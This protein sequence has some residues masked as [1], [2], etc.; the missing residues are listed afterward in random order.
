MQATFHIVLV[1]S[2]QPALNPRLVKEADALTTSGY[3]VT[4]IYQ[5]WNAWGTEIDQ[6]ILPVKK[7]NAIRIGGTPE[8]HKALYWITRVRHKAVKIL[9]KLVGFKYW[10]A[11]RSLSRCTFLLL[12]D[13][14]RQRA[15]LY[16]AH[17]LAALPVAVIAAKK[18]KA[19][20][21]FDAE[22]FH[23]NEITNNPYHMDVRLK[24]FLEEKYIP[25]T[26]YLT[27]SSPAIAALYQQLFPSKK[28]VTVL[29]AFPVV[30]EVSLPAVKA[31]EPLKLFWFS[32]TIGLNRGLQ[33]VLSAL[34]FLEDKQI[35]L[36]L[37]GFI[38]K[39]TRKQLDIIIQELQFANKPNIV[40]HQPI[41]PDKIPL[42]AAQF[43]VGLAL[44]PGFS[45]NNNVALSNKIFTYLQAGLTVVAS[46]TT[47]QK[48]FINKNPALGFCY[49]KGNG[50]Q[51]TAILKRLI[52]EPGLLLQTKQE[53]FK[54]ARNDLNWETESLKFLKVVEETIAI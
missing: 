16:I 41:N 26:D 52:N 33:D 28:A 7:W 12:K 24:T 51:L 22:D 42:F 35:E 43:D 31:A 5:Y 1:T 27:A 21:G 45:L 48:Q 25:K 37:L 29:N 17:N 50:Q 53:A 3:K 39:E 36:H 8:T 10:L 11:E 47:A 40:F 4:V 23:R 30:K 9:I 34:K 32:Q 44:E 13:A 46:D 19:K 49:E 18:N 54:A 38:D 15:D 20:C 6:Q 2:G 14:L